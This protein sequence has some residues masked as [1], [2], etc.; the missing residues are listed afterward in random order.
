MLIPLITFDFVELWWL[1]FISHYFNA[2]NVSITKITISIFNFCQFSILYP[3]FYS[4]LSIFN[5]KINVSFQ[6]VS[7]QFSIYNLY[8]YVNFELFILLVF[9]SNVFI[10]L[11]IINFHALLPLINHLNSF[12]YIYFSEHLYRS[13]SHF[14]LIRNKTNTNKKGNNIY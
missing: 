14:Q 5:H 4:V 2:A 7:S 13:N 12:S 1:N 8:Q 6:F 11:L 9:Q 3:I 10:L